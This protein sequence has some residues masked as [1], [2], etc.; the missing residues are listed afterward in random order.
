MLYNNEQAVVADYAR[1]VAMHCTSK[2]HGTAA[3][4]QQ[5]WSSLLQQLAAAFVGMHM[6]A[7][8]IHNGWFA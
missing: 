5:P 3:Q 1:P 7:K 2:R 4:D 6:H 8:I